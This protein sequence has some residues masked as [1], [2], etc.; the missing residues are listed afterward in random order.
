MAD[1]QQQPEKKGPSKLGQ[2]ISNVITT[3]LK[4]IG[5]GKAVKE[6]VREELQYKLY[7]GQDLL[8]IQPVKRL[9]EK[10]LLGIVESRSNAVSTVEANWDYFEDRRKEIENLYADSMIY[11]DP[12]TSDWEYKLYQEGFDA[13]DEMVDTTTRGKRYKYNVPQLVKIRYPIAGMKKEWIVKVSP[14]GYNKRSLY[15]GSYV[16][17]VKQI[18]NEAKE[19]ALRTAKTEAERNAIDSRIQMIS[20]VYEDVIIEVI[21]K[22]ADKIEAPYY[23][24]VKAASE[25]SLKI[26]GKYTDLLAKK[27]RRQDVVY[28]NTYK[29]VEPALYGKKSES[30]IIK[31]R[32]SDPRYGWVVKENELGPGLDEFGYP[33]EVDEDGIVMID[34]HPEATGTRRRVPSQFIKDL[35]LLETV[36]YINSFHDTYRDDLRDGRYHPFSTS[37][38]EYVQSNNKSLWDLWSI[39]AEDQIQSQSEFEINLNNESAAGAGAKIKVNVKP[40]DKNPAFDL[41]FLGGGTEGVPPWR[42]AGRKYYYDTPEGTMVGKNTESHISSRGVSMYIIEKLTREM[43]MFDEAIAVLNEIGTKGGLDYGTRPWDLWGKKMIENV[44]DWRSVIDRVN[45]PLKPE[46][47]AEEYEKMYDIK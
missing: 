3:V 30:G 24:F 25:S 9:K 15:T 21:T 13:P 27:F 38:I 17:L 16:E 33:L 6:V 45:T 40:S 43:Q 37:I 47:T 39:R 7:E 12:I 31:D 46:H 23:N 44:Y 18:C 32:L 20:G 8:E 28:Y 10:N 42:H 41:K 22:Y 36:N 19:N 2:R 26:Q 34:K 4:S 29:V 14:F 1:A 35:D 5:V 11:I